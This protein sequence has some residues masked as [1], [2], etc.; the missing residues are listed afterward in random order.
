MTEDRRGR[1]DLSEERCPRRGP[2][3]SWCAPLSVPPALSP[4]P[5]DRRGG[6]Q[7]LR[8]VHQEPAHRVRGFRPLPA[9]PIPAPL[10]GRAQVSARARGGWGHPD[11]V[12]EPLRCPHSPWSR[13]L[14][15]AGLDGAADLVCP[16]PVVREA[17]TGAGR[18]QGECQGPPGQRKGFPQE[19]RCQNLDLSWA[20][21]DPASKAAGLG[22]GQ[23]VGRGD[24]LCCCPALPRTDSCTP[25][26][27]ALSPPARRGHLCPAFM[28][29]AAS[30]GLAGRFGVSPLW[31]G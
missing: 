19:H 6:D 20:W 28:C 4:C 10:Q 23:A 21:A 16:P 18:T 1:R 29:H 27:A 5:P 3:W 26:P 11:L 31:P 22:D 2:S 14:A 9:A 17:V 30:G 12:T 7:I 25:S 24:G 13:P 8:R 15:R